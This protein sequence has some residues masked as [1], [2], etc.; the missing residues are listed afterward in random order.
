MSKPKPTLSDILETFTSALDKQAAEETAKPEEAGAK[1]DTAD[2]PSAEETADKPSV[3]DKKRPEAAE[4][5]SESEQEKKASDSGEVPASEAGAVL[6][7]MAKT[8]SVAES[9]NLRKEAQ[10]FGKAFASS[11][12]DEVRCASATEQALANGYAAT[13]DKV[14]EMEADRYGEEASTTAYTA[15]LMKVAAETAYAQ[16]SNV[17]LNRHLEKVAEEAY[18][19][20]LPYVANAQSYTAALQKCAESDSGGAGSQEAILK[21][22]ALSAY[23]ETINSIAGEVSTDVAAE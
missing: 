4:D 6:R 15:T 19:S 16:C 23:V 9:E 3:E 5:G 1:E 14:A 8:A 10:E 17:L 21:T 11:F 7:D 2:K 20:T 18:A 13:M 12:L 22:A